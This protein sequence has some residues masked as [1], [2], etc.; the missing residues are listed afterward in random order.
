M[1]KKKRA[2][3]ESR[4]IYAIDGKVAVDFLGRYETLNQDFH[5]ALADIGISAGPLPTANA[6]DKPRD[7]YREFYND[8]T[9]KLVAEW[10]ALEIA[11]QGYEF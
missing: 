3:V 8:T 6:S 7:R 2:F 10:Y 9:R 1:A 11:E 4:D 5:K